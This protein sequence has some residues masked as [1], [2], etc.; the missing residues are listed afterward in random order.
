MATPATRHM[1]A[2]RR[3]VC[4][5]RARGLHHHC[6]LFVGPQPPKTISKKTKEI[7][8]TL[9]PMAGRH[10]PEED[11]ALG[12][13]PNRPDV[14]L[15]RGGAT[16]LVDNE[17]EEEYEDAAAAAAAP[18]AKSKPRRGSST[19]SKPPKAAEREFDIVIKLLLLGDSGVGKTSIMMR[20]SEKQF[21]PSLMSTAGCVLV[22]TA[23]Q[24]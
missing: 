15:A 5:L 13:A 4:S 20:Y 6:C 24:L 17:L 22:P 14:A 7:L 2:P 23:C 10:D 1:C 16:V 12:M 21:S 11:L 3:F 18:P 9:D 8:T 19:G